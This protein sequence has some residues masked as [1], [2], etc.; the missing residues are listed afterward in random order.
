MLVL[1]NLHN[2]AGNEGLAEYKVDSYGI[3][4][5]A[6][7]YLYANSNPRRTLTVYLYSMFLSR[8]TMQL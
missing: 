5:Y 2:S 7:C 6:A 3:T 8:C 4:A 1:K